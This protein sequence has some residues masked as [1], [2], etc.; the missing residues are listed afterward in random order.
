MYTENDLYDGMT[1]YWGRGINKEEIYT[2]NKCNGTVTSM[3]ENAKPCKGYDVAE[4]VKQLNNGFCKLRS[5]NECVDY[6]FN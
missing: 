2:W 5:S 3:V 4:I 6:I 1:L